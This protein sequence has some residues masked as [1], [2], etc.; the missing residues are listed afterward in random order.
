MEKVKRTKPP[1]TCEQ[2]GIVVVDKF[3]LKR[4]VRLKNISLFLLWCGL[5]GGGGFGEMNLTC[6]YLFTKL[7]FQEMS[8]FS[9]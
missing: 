8:G 4:H 6:Y 5:L 3:V 7:C 9:G 1:V 2:C